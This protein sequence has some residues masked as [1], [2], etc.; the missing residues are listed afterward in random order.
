MTMA[1]G[2]K[3]F[4]QCVACVCLTFGTTFWLLRS[5]RYFGSWW[6]WWLYR[7]HY[8]LNNINL[9]DFRKWLVYKDFIL[10]DTKLLVQ[11]PWP[12]RKHNTIFI[13]SISNLVFLTCSILSAKSDPLVCVDLVFWKELNKCFLYFFLKSLFFAMLGIPSTPLFCWLKWTA[14]CKLSKSCPLLTKILPLRWY[15]KSK[16]TWTVHVLVVATECIQFL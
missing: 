12:S 4:Y 16:C 9:L 1:R 14:L 13:S 3:T 5:L 15:L 8:Q 6:V 2:K 10:K 7:L 11:L